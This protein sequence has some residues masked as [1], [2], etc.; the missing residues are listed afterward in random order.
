VTRP[1]AG[2]WQPSQLQLDRIHYRRSRARRSLLIGALSTVVVLGAITLLVTHAQGWPATRASFFDFPVGWDGLGDQLR[3]L[4]INIQV[5]LIAEVCVLVLASVIAFLRTLRAPA[6]FPL[7]F[8]ATVYVD[9][10]RGMPLLIVIYLVM[11]GVPSLHISYLPTSFFTL[12][13]VALTLTYSAYVAEV[14]RAGIESVHASQS[15]A[16]RSLGLTYGQAMRYVIFPQG[17]RRVLPPL[18]NDMVSLQKDTSLVS[19][20]GLL[21]VVLTA[22]NQNSQ[23][24]KFV[25]YV[26]AGLVFVAI[27]VPLTR[28]TDW[29]ARRRGWVGGAAI[30]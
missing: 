29:Y 13:I 24:F 30:I 21:E 20:G 7:R 8:L 1:E 11:Y 12:A 6:F 4:W 9:L 22:Q 25:H 28:V 27:S 2:S 18:L 14:L 3:A 5:W 16:A 26:I 15:A 10:F 17:V 19:I 23:D